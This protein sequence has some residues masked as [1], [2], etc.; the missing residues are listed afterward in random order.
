MGIAAVETLATR[1][2]LRFGLERRPP[3]GGSKD[4]GSFGWDTDVVP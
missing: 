3:G 2:D 1:K 4:D